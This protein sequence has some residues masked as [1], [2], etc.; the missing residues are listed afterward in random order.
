MSYYQRGDFYPPGY[1]VGDPFFG[2]LGSLISK[3]AP[4]VGKLFHGGSGSE[5]VRS[6]G[7]GPIVSAGR[8]AGRMIAKHPVLSAA[9]AAGA[10]GAAGMGVHHLMHHPGR[11]H[12][13]M[14]AC[15]PRALRRALRRAHA[16]AKFAHKVIRVQHKFKKPRGAW[17]RSH[18]KKHARA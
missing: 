3:A 5:I 8:S 12:R 6:A 15:N 1:S 17:P 18:A 2:F 7:G 16:F 11:R 14:N 9:G 10:I 13:R 4:I